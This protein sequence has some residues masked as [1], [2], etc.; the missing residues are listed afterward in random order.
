M[1]KISEQR[2]EDILKAAGIEFKSNGV[3]HASISDIAARAGIGKS[4]VY[5][6]FPSK[7]DLLAAFCSR[8]LQEF[9]TLCCSVFA[10]DLPLRRLLVQFVELI[11]SEI[12]HI[13]LPSV[14]S[15]LD[16]YPKIDTLTRHAE[17]LRDHISAQLKQTLLRAQARGELAT[18]LNLDAATCWLLSLPQPQLYLL[19][20]SRDVDDPVGLM[21]DYALNGLAPRP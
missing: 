14:L 15:L 18:G 20:K 17:D 4:T 21:V 6:Y 12:E 3:D 9:D 13:D 16:N 1:S 11:I 7:A 5:E 2:R 10:Q 19:L 8:K